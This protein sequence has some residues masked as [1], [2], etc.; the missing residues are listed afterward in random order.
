MSGPVTT[1]EG[2]LTPDKARKHIEAIEARVDW[3]QLKIVAKTLTGKQ[4]YGSY[5]G[6]ELRALQWALVLAESEWIYLVRADERYD[7][8]GKVPSPTLTPQ[9]QRQRQRQRKAKADDQMADSGMAA[10][11]S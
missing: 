5:E 4:M 11:A 3:L 1:E 7:I 8:R 10:E 9:Q 2:L 6:A